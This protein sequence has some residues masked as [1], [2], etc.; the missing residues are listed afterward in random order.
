M[1]AACYS[2]NARDCA[3]ACGPAETCPAGLSCVGGLCR[4]A[5]HEPSCATG[6]T[7]DG[8]TGDGA[9]SCGW[10]GAATTF[11]PSNFGPSSLPARGAAW[12]VDGAVLLDT[13]TG[14]GGPTGIPHQQAW[15]IY[16]DSLTVTAGATLTVV[17][18]RPLIVVADTITVDG[19]IRVLAGSD[20]TGCTQAVFNSQSSC[21]AAGGSGGGGF[22]GNGGRGRNMDGNSNYVLGGAANGDPL[23]TPLRG[24]CS[25]AKGGAGGDDTLDGGAGGAGGG[26]IQLSA[27]YSLIVRGMINAGGGGGGG[28]QARTAPSGASCNVESSGG[29]GGGSGGAILLEGCRVEVASAGFACASGGGGGGGEDNVSSVAAAGPDGGC[30]ALPG[31]AGGLG[32]SNSGGAGGFDTSANGQDGNSTNDASGGGG[33]GAVGRIR[34]RAETTLISGS[35]FPAAT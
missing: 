21:H 19:T 16:V 11:V 28:G 8:A 6:V 14:N 4:T 20:G 34:I 18:S 30:T 26:G 2:P 13:S 27:Q 33:G 22:G 17:G 32:A 35:V 12:T 10:S 5:D 23:L 1:M 7:I 31:G 29:G 25:G 9:Q 15:L 3:Y 24:G